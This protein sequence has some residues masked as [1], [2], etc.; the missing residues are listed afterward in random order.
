MSYLYIRFRDVFEIVAGVAIGRGEW[1]AC[2]YMRKFEGSSRFWN[3]VQLAIT[4]TMQ[5]RLHCGRYL[6]LEVW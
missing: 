3:S 2:K 5:I 6:V 1:N 4:M